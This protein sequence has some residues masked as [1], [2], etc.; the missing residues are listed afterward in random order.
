MFGLK[1]MEKLLIVY[2]FYIKN[3]VNTLFTC[4]CACVF[5]LSW[6]SFEG[7]SFS[8]SLVPINFIIVGSCL[9]EFISTSFYDFLPKVFPRYRLGIVI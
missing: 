2:I 4:Q 3:N 1:G 5:H 8:I 7:I 9:H 6:C